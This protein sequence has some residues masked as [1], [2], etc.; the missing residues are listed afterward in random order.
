MLT[1]EN[2][3]L[4]AAFILALCFAYATTGCSSSERSFSQ[5]GPTV[6]TRPAMASE[7]PTG[8]TVITVDRNPPTIVCNGAV[9]T[10]GQNGNDGSDGQDGVDATP[11]TIVTLCPGVTSYPGVFVEVAVCLQGNLYAVYSVPNAF[12]TYIPPGNYTS[13]GIGSSCN[14]TVHP[15]CVVT[16]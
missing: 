3:G 15:N 9:G 10:P 6:T 4:L 8:G 11:V 12:L 5:V 1:K 2:L 7:C 16:H 13:N 14:L